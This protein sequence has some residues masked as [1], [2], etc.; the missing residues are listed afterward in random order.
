MRSRSRHWIALLA[1]VV[2]LLAAC[3][4]STDDAT[5]ATLAST[6]TAAETTTTTLP[7]TTTTTSATDDA[8]AEV[9]VT[10]AGFGV[11][12]NAYDTEAIREYVTD[13]AT[14]E[15]T[16][17]VQ[18]LD[19][20]LA[21]VDRYYEATDFHVEAI[22]EPV[23]TLDGDE[24]V[25]VQL[26]AVASTGFEAVGTSTVRLVEVDGEWLIREVRWVEE[27]AGSTE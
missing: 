21:H 25:V 2:L 7:P 16:G 27:A 18:T 15:S 10:V 20:Y 14:W 26:E 8:E 5:D 22:S 12:V 1:A 13:D 24:Y 3:G 23:V 11:A 19:R 4:E 17:P 6:T 9:L